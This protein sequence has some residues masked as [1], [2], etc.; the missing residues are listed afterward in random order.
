MAVSYNPRIVTDGLVLAL[1]AANP[2]S[3]VNIPGIT[4]HGIS[5]WY[6]FVS[7]TVTYSAIYPNTQIIEIDSN[8][9]ETVMVTTGSDPQRGTFSITAGR[10]YYG[11]KAI[12]LMAEDNQ[13]AISPAS[14][15]GIYF[16]HY[17][18]R[19]SPITYYA[20][21]PQDD[22]QLQFFDNNAVDGVDGTATATYNIPIGLSTSF[23]STAQS[24]WQFF[25]ANKPII[26]TAGA[27]SS[28]PSS[29]DRTVLSP[30]SQYVYKRRD[31]NNRTINNTAPS[32]SLTYVTYDNS[33][34]V[35]TVEIADGSGLD[36][37]QGIGY[38]YL[39]DT[40]SWGNVLSDYQIVAPYADTAVTVSYWANNQWNVGE[41][42]SLSGTQTNPDAVDRDGTNGF[43]VDGTTISG[44]ASNLANGANLWKWESTKPIALIINDSADDEE[45]MLG[46]MS[47]NYIRTSSNVDQ[48][49]VNLVDRE[50][51]SQM[52]VYGKNL[53]TDSNYAGAK[54]SASQYI[55]FDGSDDYVNLGAFFTYQ[56]FTISLWVYPGST[57][58]QYADIF[59][60][61]HTGVRNF[62]L[63]QNDLDTN[64]YSF[65]VHDASGGI[66]GTSIIALNAFTWYNLSFTFTPSDRV[67][68]YV[69]GEFHSQGALAGGRNIL[70]QSQTLSIARWSA[71]GRHWNGRMGNF[72]TYNRVLTASEISQNFNATRSRYGI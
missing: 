60:N 9:N 17:W 43:G 7:G 33:L 2:K 70:Y 49:L 22:T 59:D 1:D 41:V 54:L 11:T 16:A 8:G 37:C 63:Q 67:I 18:N 23:Q 71:G 21:A 6:C 35:M 69:N 58:V 28:T 10:R 30:A 31:A 66:S 39:S 15:A 3:Y 68:G 25:K 57:Q 53:T 50:I 34:P 20:Y 51:T 46:W 45:N 19:N 40:F 47:N 32:T 26:M 48:S 61:N 27:T 56:E 44:G 24:T 62:V 38:E 4:D 65:G 42:H 14:L 13:Y 12:H 52:T 36:A 5:D 72:M 55:E 29:S 64:Q